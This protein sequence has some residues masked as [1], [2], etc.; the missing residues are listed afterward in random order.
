MEMIDIQAATRQFESAANMLANAR[1]DLEALPQAHS[2]PEIQAHIDSFRKTLNKLFRDTSIA[3]IACYKLMPSQMPLL[4]NYPG[5]LAKL[6]AAQ[7]RFTMEHNQTTRLFNK[8]SDPPEAT[9]GTQ[10]G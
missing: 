1:Q 7:N 5:E 10:A 9:A 4:L 3:A 2:D 8:V 6:I